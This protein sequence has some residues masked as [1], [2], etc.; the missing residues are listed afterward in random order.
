MDLNCSIIIKSIGERKHSI[1]TG[2]MN[3]RID[4]DDKFTY[5]ILF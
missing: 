4:R 3:H 1:R 2:H 5:H